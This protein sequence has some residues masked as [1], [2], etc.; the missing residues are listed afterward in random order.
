MALVVVALSYSDKILGLI[1]NSP[2]KHK[3]Q[4]IYGGV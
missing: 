1:G 4:T 2:R 3:K